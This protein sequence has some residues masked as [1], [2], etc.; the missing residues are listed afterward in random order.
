MRSTDAAATLAVLASLGALS[1]PRPDAEA[2]ADLHEWL[3]EEAEPLSD[4]EVVA[5]LTGEA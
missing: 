1:V 2:V 4:E 3:V 5:L